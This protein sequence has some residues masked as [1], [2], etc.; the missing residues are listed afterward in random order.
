M[1]KLL[2]MME[3]ERR[4][5]K[6]PFTEKKE[7]KDTNNKGSHITTTKLENIRKELTRE[8]ERTNIPIL[9]NKFQ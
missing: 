1:E 4:R 7:E 3:K 2:A 9:I 5:S 6:V 8:T